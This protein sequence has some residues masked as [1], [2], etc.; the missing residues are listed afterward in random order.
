[1]PPVVRFDNVSKLYQIGSGHGSLREALAGLSRR[2]LRRWTPDSSD[3]NSLWALK[4]VS[5][6]LEPGQVLGVVGRNGAGKTTL[7]KL[8]SRVVQ[9]SSGRIDVSGRVSALIELGA[10]F[11]PDLTGRENIYLNGAIL[12]L[13][14]KEIDRK[15]ESIVAFAELEKF[16]DTPVKRYSSGMYAR[17]G[18]AVAAHSEPDLLLVDEVLAVGDA[19]FQDKCLDFIH[20]YV[21]TGHT[22]VFVSHN[23]YAVE[24][25]CHRLI[26]IDRGK[27]MDMGNPSLVLEKYMRFMERQSGEATEAPVAGRKGLDIRGMR[28]SDSDGSDREV[29][30]NGEDVVVEV[31]YEAERPLRCPH[32]CIWI[33]DSVAPNPL[34]AANML[35]DGHAPEVI[36]GPGVVQCVFKNVPLMPRSYYVWLEVWDSDRAGILFRWQ[37]LARFQI[38]DPDLI[39]DPLNIKGSVRFSMS[40]A[41]VRIPYEW[42]FLPIA[43]DRTPLAVLRP[44]GKTSRARETE[45]AHPRERSGPAKGR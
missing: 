13:S 24:Q 39:G 34:L 20:S 15:F 41:P 22:T 2:L 18:F 3:A 14:R 29:F 44:N 30:R 40:H 35:L 17:L 19:N 42:R 21:N 11:H 37:R 6:E 10:G 45:S 38:F 16:I 23:L 36:E 26:W 5:F 8:L 4:D 7:L 32:F 12:G 27:T 1:M 9:P 43:T 28:I 31:R 25:L 33:S